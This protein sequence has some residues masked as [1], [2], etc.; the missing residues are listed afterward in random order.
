MH[1]KDRGKLFWGGIYKKMIWD[2]AFLLYFFLSLVSLYGFILFSWWWVKIG[3]VSDVYAYVTYLFASL[4][5][6]NAP[7]AYVRYVFVESGTNVIY[8]SIVTS[9]IWTLRSTPCLIVISVLVVKMTLRAYRTIRS[10][11]RFKVE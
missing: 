10:A 6:I 1:P 2:T 3:E 8:D 9:T 4:V 11:K 7:Q 5:F